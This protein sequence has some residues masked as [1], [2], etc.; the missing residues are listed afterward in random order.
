MEE[1]FIIVRIKIK[2][3]VMK[4][5]Y[6]ENVRNRE[7]FFCKNLK[8]IQKIDGVDYLRVFR[9]GTQRDCLVKLDSLR[10]IPEQK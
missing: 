9:M 1:Y 7:K 8:D 2:E 5:T 3:N 10:K 6:F 4:T